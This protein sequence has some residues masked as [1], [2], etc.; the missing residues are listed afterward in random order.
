[1]LTRTSGV[2]PVLVS[3]SAPAGTYAQPDVYENSPARMIA[4][5]L[6]SWLLFLRVS[7]L[8]QTLVY[9]FK[10]NLR[11][12]YLVGV[13]ALLGLVV[14]G[15]LQR[16]FRGKPT[17][18]WTGFAL[19]M[20]LA[21]PF[22]SWRGGS[23]PLI[24]DYYR[25]DLVM[26]FIAGGLAV[27]WRDCNMLMRAVAAGAVIDLVTARLFSDSSELAYRV[28]IQ[29]GTV[30]NANDFAGH[31]AFALPFLLWAGLAAKNFVLRAGAL[32]GVAYGVYVILETGSRGGEVALAVAALFFLWRATMRQRLVFA[33]TVPIALAGLGVVVS[34]DTWKHLLTFSADSADAMPEAVAS[35]QQRM[36][37][38][39]Q[40]LIYTSEHPLFGVGP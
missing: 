3:G 34:R 6:G 12:L 18:F 21:V 8:H 32:A 22:S 33:V 2:P 13:P 4:L 30:A 10:V 37:L 31:L 28:G 40:S 24:L 11:L 1:M 5:R 36:Y 38:L 9:L 29:F 35:S 14:A 15:G 16:S 7:M 20:T 25:T 26:L 27:T 39:K 23:L 19:W 17:W